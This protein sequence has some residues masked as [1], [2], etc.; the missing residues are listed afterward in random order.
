M[1]VVVAA[2]DV[3]STR[4]GYEDGRFILSEIEIVVQGH[5]R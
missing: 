3:K 5:C 2:S 4:L 1:L